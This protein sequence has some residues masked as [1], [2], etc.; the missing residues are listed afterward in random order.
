[1]WRLLLRIRYYPRFVEIAQIQAKNAEFG[2]KCVTRFSPPSFLTVSLFEPSSLAQQLVRFP[3]CVRRS[4]YTS[5]TSGNIREP[6]C[7]TPKKAGIKSFRQSQSHHYFTSD[8]NRRNRFLK[9]VDSISD[10]IIT[11]CGESKYI[12][13]LRLHYNQ[14]G[15]QKAWD[16]IKNHD[17]VCVLLFNRQRE[18]FVFVRQFRPIIY[19]NRSETYEENGITKIDS[20][21]FS[22][23][24]GI[25]TELCAGIVDKNLSLQ[26]IVQEEIMEECGYKVP[27]DNIERVASYR[28]GV[29]TTGA[30]ATL[31]YAEITDKMKVGKGGGLEEEGERIDVIEVPVSEAKAYVMDDS[32]PKPSGIMF[33]VFWFFDAKWKK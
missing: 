13:P 11:P 14:S 12:K 6:V 30:C 24:L 5:A 3:S 16:V 26:E 1:M 29:S 33:A 9:M 21:K 23:K 19:M 2:E 32:I 20:S 17:S 8:T 27:L 4:V 10:M 22:G 25:T 31:F 15:S 18:V 28:S 7:C